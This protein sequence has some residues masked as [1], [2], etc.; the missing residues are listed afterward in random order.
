MKPADWQWEVDTQ[1]VSVCTPLVMS[2]LQIEASAQQICE[3]IKDQ[4]LHYLH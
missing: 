1:H 3:G 4:P 2:P